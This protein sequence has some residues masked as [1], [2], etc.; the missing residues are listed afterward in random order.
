M[1]VAGQLHTAEAKEQRKR[2]Q[3][4]VKSL[5][6]HYGIPSAIKA[7]KDK[8]LECCCDNKAEIR[9]CHHADCPLF[10]YRFGR[11]PKPA[12]LKV[13]QHDING[14]PIAEADYKGYKVSVNQ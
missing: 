5:K 1:K 4:S 14:E 6:R 9:R 13:P 7:I 3:A 10:P 12:D 8:C 2:S 11:S